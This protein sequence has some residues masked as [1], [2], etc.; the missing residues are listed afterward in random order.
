MKESANEK[1]ADSARHAAFQVPPWY[2]D[3]R[4]NYRTSRQL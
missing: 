3:I 1:D 2:M 4:Y